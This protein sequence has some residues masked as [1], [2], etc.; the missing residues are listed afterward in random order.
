MTTGIDTVKSEVQR[1]L[2]WMLDVQRGFTRTADA[3]D[4]A[5]EVL[6]RPD[7]GGMVWCPASLA[8]DLCGVIEEARQDQGP[9]GTGARLAC[10]VD[11]LRQILL[12]AEDRARPLHESAQPAGEA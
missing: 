3:R 4:R 8:K 12:A 2:R 6:E 7:P 11:E 1:A 5:I 9:L 10:T